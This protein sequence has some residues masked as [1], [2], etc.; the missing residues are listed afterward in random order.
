MTKKFFLFW[1]LL[2]FCTFCVS[3]QKVLAQC[4]AKQI[5]K[6]CKPNIQP[7][8]KYDSY[9]RSEITFGDKKQL[10]EV[11]FTAFAGQ[12]YRLF[13][14]SSGFDEQ[15]K[16][17]I[18]DKPLRLKAG[19]NKIYDNSQGIDSDFW[20]FEP[21]KP[22]KYYINYEIAPSVDGKLKDACVVLLVSLTTEK[23]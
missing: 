3:P 1:S 5:M 17:N 6:G 20:T 19:R 13:F 8:Y 14:C 16:L 9:V 7:P 23:K 18:Y 4:H 12:K 2:L 15:V 11:V 21:T 22:G 10:V